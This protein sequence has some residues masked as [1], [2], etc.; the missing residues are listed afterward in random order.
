MGSGIAKSI[1][2]KWPEVYQADFFTPR[3]DKRKLGTF[4]KATV[5]D[6]KLVYNLY[7]QFK[8]DASSRQLDYQAFEDALKAMRQDL[9]D[10]G[11]YKTCKLGLPYKIGCGLAGGDWTVVSEIINKVFVDKAIYI[12]RQ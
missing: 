7:G 10:L 4:S 8:A 5:D 1:R 9:I 6:N 2:A 11:I 12:Y 3:G